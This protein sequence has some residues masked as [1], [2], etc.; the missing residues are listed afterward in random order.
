MADDLDTDDELEVNEGSEQSG[1]GGREHQR[2]IEKENKR[3]RDEAAQANAKAAEAEA[4]KR[5]NLF[6]KAGVTNIDSGVGQLLYKGYEGELTVEAI[7]A[8]ASEVNLIP[9]SEQPDVAQELDALAS[10][11]QVSQSAAGSG[12]PDAV[13]QIKQKG[14]TRE[15]IIEIAVKNGSRISDETPGPITSLV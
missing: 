7:R 2:K 3:L 1:N 10:T 15:Q 4:I 14:L 6:L 9:T 12:T 5:E 13:T 11:R 8:A